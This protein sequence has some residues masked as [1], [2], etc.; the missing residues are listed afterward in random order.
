MNT[1]FDFWIGRWNV[2][3]ERLKGR[4]CGETEWETFSA[5]AEARFLPEASA[6]SINSS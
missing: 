2:R 3:N 5:S 1:D 6:I 4:L